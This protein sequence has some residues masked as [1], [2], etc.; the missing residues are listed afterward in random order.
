MLFRVV[1]LCCVVLR[2]VVLCC[3]VLCCVMFVVLFCA[4]VEFCSFFGQLAYL[5]CEL[6]CESYPPVSFATGHKRYIKSLLKNAEGHNKMMRNSVF[7]LL[8]FNVAIC[9]TYSS[10]N[11]VNISNIK[12]R[13]DINGKEMDIH[14]AAVH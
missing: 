4:T 2:C 13:V 5:L 9:L 11:T 1:S 3:V 10:G 8:A 14:G 7:A 12:P 6:L